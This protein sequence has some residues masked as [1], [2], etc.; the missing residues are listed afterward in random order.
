MCFANAVLQVLLY[1]P[2]FW[3][4]F[5]ELGKLMGSST[6]GTKETPLVNATVEFLK[7]FKMDEVDE[8][9]KD[10]KRKQ[11]EEEEEGKDSFL[12][13]FVYD[14]LKQKKRFDN[15][16]VSRV[17]ILLIDPVLN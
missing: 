3:R 5:E 8:K 14:A 2:P 15:M 1:C 7:E 17:F 16:R 4:L 9:G 10:A 6:V 12:P 11:R 13:G